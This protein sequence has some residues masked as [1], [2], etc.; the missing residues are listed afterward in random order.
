MA[1]V[2][3]IHA[4]DTHAQDIHTQ[5]I[6]TQDI[7]TQDTHVAIYCYGSECSNILYR[8]QF[9]DCNKFICNKC[10]EIDSYVYNNNDKKAIIC[11]DCLPYVAINMKTKTIRICRQKNTQVKIEP[12]KIEWITKNGFN[13]LSSNVGVFIM[14]TAAATAVATAAIVLSITSP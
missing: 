6:H 3:D 14:S 7:H 13:P 9:P 11:P 12:S 10:A 5:D 8:C 4:Q 2:Q 1:F